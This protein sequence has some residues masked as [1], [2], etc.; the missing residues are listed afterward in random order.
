MKAKI[1]VEQFIFEM[2]VTGEEYEK[3]RALV[4]QI[5]PQMASMMEAMKPIEELLRGMLEKI[6]VEFIA[7][8]AV[9][10]RREGVLV[11]GMAFKGNREAIERLAEAM[12]IDISGGEEDVREEEEI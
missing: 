5:A 3:V 7:N 2:S 10:L 12:G 6:G 4:D 8:Q 1:R 11:I 9:Y